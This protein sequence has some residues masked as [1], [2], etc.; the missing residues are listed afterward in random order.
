MEKGRKML[1]ALMGLEIGG[2]E[3]H[4]VEL[5]KELKRQGYDIVVASNGGVY[6]K[7]LSEAGIK[8]YKVPLNNKNPLNFIKSY[9]LLKD[10][11]VNENIKL[12]HAHARIPGFICGLLKKRLGFTFVTTAHWVFYTGMGLK[13]ITNWGEKVIAVSEDIKKY[14]MDNYKTKEENIYLTINGI[15]TDKFSPDIVAPEIMAEFNICE[16]DTVIVYVSRMDADRA[17]AAWELIEC[18]PLLNQKMEHLKVIIVG[19]GNQY[20]DMVKKVKLMNKQLHKEMIYMAGARTDINRL[21]SVA[22]IF[23]GV[24]RSALE[25][26][27]AAKPVILAG[28]EGYLGLFDMDKLDNAVE[29]N[30]TLRGNE[31]SSSQKLLNDILYTVSLSDEK[32][33]QLGRMGRE[34]IFE[35][36]SVNKMAKDCEKAYDA[37]LVGDSKEVMILG[38][39]GFGN[40]GDE[41]TLSAIINMIN[42]TRQDTK[43]NVLSYNGIE[44]YKT[45]GVNGISRNHYNQILAAIKRSDIVICGGGTILQDVTSSRSLYYYLTIIWL[46]KKCHKKIVFFSNGFGPIINNSAITSK[47]CNRADCIIVRD[48]KSKQ[49]MVEMGIVKKIYVSTDVVFN[50]ENSN[51]QKKNKIAISL[52]PWK[53]SKELVCQVANAANKLI[54]KGYEID[55]I[56]LHKSRDEKVL[57]LLLEKIDKKD[58]VCLYKGENYKQIMDRIGESKLMIGMR[59]HANIFALINDMPIITIDYD[60]KIE[61]LA[62]DFEQPIIT[63]QDHQISDKIL[64]AVMDIEQNYEQKVNVIKTKTNEKRELLSIN[65]KYLNKNL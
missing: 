33:Q 22:D 56:S 19:A 13:Y 32:R 9:Y 48:E 57:S 61:A 45:H 23:I 52:R 7:E 3:T 20:E 64:N 63:M 55:L 58:K 24:S 2:A 36:Y 34:V 6:E 12:V 65:Y 30:F 47:I 21:V 43:I 46:A 44:T 51:I 31:L 38:Y 40:W 8:H 42:Q 10:I 27:A 16:R 41:A 53:H 15:D 14:L 60:P 5:V 28:N 50:F 37:A 54:E 4:V 35:H 18:V 59:L 25:A 1:H 39:Y 11:I 49:M 62:Y 17:K 26:M 29:S